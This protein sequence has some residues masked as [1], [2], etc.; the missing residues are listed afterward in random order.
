VSLVGLIPLISNN[1]DQY[2]RVDNL[3]LYVILL[4]E[5]SCNSINPLQEQ[6][7]VYPMEQTINIF[8]R[9]DVLVNNASIVE[10]T[11]TREKDRASQSSS[12]SPA[13]LDTSRY[14]Q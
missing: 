6:T 3:M 11:A 9:I 5:N 10:K 12:S 7:C 8:R 1:T 14:K 4:N 2:E 13:N